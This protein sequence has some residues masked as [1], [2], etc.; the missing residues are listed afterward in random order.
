MISSPIMRVISSRDRRRVARHR[1]ARF[2]VLAVMSLFVLGA[3]L[4]KWVPE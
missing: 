3:V 4:L 2:L 1:L